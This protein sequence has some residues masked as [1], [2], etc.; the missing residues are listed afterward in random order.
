MAMQVHIVMMG[1]AA[2]GAR[3]LIFAVVGFTRLLQAIG[4]RTMQY[5]RK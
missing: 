4:T 1:H 3:R 5:H 2:L